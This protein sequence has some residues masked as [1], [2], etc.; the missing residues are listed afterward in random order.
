MPNKETRNGEGQRK[1]YYGKR[2]SEHFSLSS[3][4]RQEFQV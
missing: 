2:Q 4:Y 3:G 1:V